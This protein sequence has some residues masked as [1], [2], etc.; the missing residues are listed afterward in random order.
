MTRRSGLRVIGLLPFAALATFIACAPSPTAVDDGSGDASVASPP[1]TVQAS[2]PPNFFA[3]PPDESR[4]IVQT[5]AQVQLSQAAS[6]RPLREITPSMGETEVDVHE[7]RILPPRPS[8]PK[9]QIDPV[10]DMKAPPPLM[11]APNESFIGQG[12]T[13]SNSTITGTPPDPNGAVGPN[14]F[15]QIVNGGIAI[16]NKTGSLLWGS[17]STNVLWNG[18]STAD[19]NGCAASNDGDAVVVYDKWADRWFI[20]QFD[21]PNNNGPDWQC[22]AVSQTSDPTGAYWL[23]DFKYQYFNDYGKFSVWPDAYYSTFNMFGNGGFKGADYCAYDRVSMLAGNPATQQCFQQGATIGGDL[24]AS[25]DGQVAPPRGEPGFILDPETNALD[26]YK[27]HVDW[28]TP[29]NTTLTGPTSIPVANYTTA[30]VKGCVP[31]PGTAEKLDTLSDRLMFRLAYRNFGDH[32]SL[33]VNQTV[34]ANGVM[35]VRWYELRAPNGTP[36]VYQQGTYAPNDTEWRWMASI[37]EDQAQDFALGFS[38]GNKTTDASVA[39]T[40]RL[41]GDALGTMGQGETTVKAGGGAEPSATRWGDYSAMTV[42]P[43]DDC[44]FWYTN[45]E[46]PKTNNAFTW[47]TWIPS[48]KFPSCAA[49]D[50]T[51]SVTPASQSVQQNKSVTYTVSTALKQGSAETIALN[52]QDLPSGVSGSFNPATVTA[53]GSSTLTLTA[54]L[55]APIVSNVTF[56]VIGTATSAVHPAT[57]QVSVVGCSKDTCGS[58][59]DNCGTPPDG[60]GGTLASCGTCSGSNTCGGGGTPYQCGCTPTTCA[61]LGDNCGTPPDGC[62]GTLASC[63]TC[64]GVNTCG[65]GGTQYQCG[66]APTTCAKLGD[67]CGTPPDGCGG[68]LASCGTCSGANTCGG[69]GTQYQCGC[70]PTTCAKL[71]DN[72]GTPP[73]GCGGTLASCGTCSGVN[74]C[75]GGGT[76]Y[77]CGCAPTTC[78]K[79]GDNCGTPPDGCGGTLASCGTC[80]GSNTC[81]GGGTQYQCGCT[82]TT[83]AKLGDNCGTPPDGCGGTLASCGTCT[84]SNTCGGGGTQ[85]QCGCTPTTCAKLG[86]NCGTPPDGCGGTL[87]SCGTCTGSNTCGGGGTQYQCGCTPTTCAKLG[88]NCGTPPDGCGGTLASCGTCSGV[89]TCGGGGTP[90]VCGCTPTTCA[91]LGDNCGTV[92]DGCGGTLNCGTCMGASTCGGGGTPNVCG[93]TP[94]TCAVLGDNCGTPPDG[95]G[96]ALSSC[97][98]CSGSNTCGGGGTPYQCGCTPTTCATLGDNCGTPPD[99]CGGTLT[100]CGTCSG[101]DTCGG[102]GTP[103]VCGCKPKTCGQVGAT[104]GQTSDGCGGTQDCGSCPPGKTCDAN[105]ACVDSPEAGTPDAGPPDAGT[106]DTGTP[107]TGMTEAGP[108]LDGSPPPGDD[109]GDDGGGDS[110][111]APDAGNGNHL[112]GGGCGCRTTGESEDGSLAIVG[113]GGLAAMVLLRARRRRR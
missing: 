21:V 22:V 30:C 14:H 55:S 31:Q 82:P 100:S 103:N 63:G 32:E 27:F 96:G 64:S 90:N 45:E 54:T 28:V 60:C 102:G 76:Q 88:D 101:S 92:P 40:G 48:F 24:P 95:C 70:T 84:G 98:T 16:W 57:A 105:N 80:T 19:G 25:A 41:N 2:P 65:G 85:Y 67:N 11:P 61:K 112:S 56:T 8:P 91:M 94:T 34:D 89:N 18:Y 69:G 81:G 6:S 58:L 111:V 72:C 37:A 73:D 49:N 106:T 12:T 36:V 83:C 87:A 66:C 7:V 77:Q 20:T 108:T 26:I 4:A 43:V 113:F 51:I 9:D 1:P 79:L 33:M 107:D 52:V 74:T 93:C 75:G 35:S 39:W 5:G 71:G 46:Y 38:I 29:A 10:V 110:G 3:G 47:D 15:V 62:G 78:A 97:G 23:Y 53:G 42:D 104:C 13:I 59:G 109:S 68:T 86:D 44:T 50:F 17:K 99:G